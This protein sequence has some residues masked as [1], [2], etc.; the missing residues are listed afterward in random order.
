MSNAT[1]A[2]NGKASLDFSDH[3]DEGSEC[4]PHFQEGLRRLSRPKQAHI[5]H[6]LAAAWPSC[7]IWQSQQRKINEIFTNKKLYFWCAKYV[8]I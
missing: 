2:V 1:I 6:P 3:D 7:A 5:D 8:A 4:H